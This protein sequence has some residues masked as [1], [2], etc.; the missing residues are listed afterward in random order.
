MKLNRKMNSHE[1]SPIMKCD[2]RA[3][4][5]PIETKWMDY[6]ASNQD[7]VSYQRISDSQTNTRSTISFAT[8]L[9]LIH[10][11]VEIYVETKQVE[12]KNTSSENTSRR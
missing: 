3:T 12:R 10:M 2:K 1:S 6:D 8:L 5:F 7:I 9:H 4:R 11:Y